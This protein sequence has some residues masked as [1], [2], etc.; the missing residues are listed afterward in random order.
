M[1]RAWGSVSARRS[2]GCAGGDQLEAIAEGIEK[3]G[4]L[5]AGNGFFAGSLKT[6]VAQHMQ[7][8]IHAVDH[9]G[10]VGFLGGDKV[11]IAAQVDLGAAA[12]KPDA[13]TDGQVGRLFYFGQAENAIE[14][15]ARDALA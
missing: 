11:G 1:V 15:C 5:A 8:I 3:G 13:T 2:L 10:R 6:I 12:L 4:A 9:E 7:D 14:E